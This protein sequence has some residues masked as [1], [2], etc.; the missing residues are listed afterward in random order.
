MPGFII[1]LPF[2]GPHLF[3]DQRH[4]E[5]FVRYLFSQSKGHPAMD[6]TAL[7]L[8]TETE[9]RR[10]TRRYQNTDPKTACNRFISERMPR[11]DAPSLLADDGAYVFFFLPLEGGGGVSNFLRPK[12]DSVA[13]VGDPRI[14]KE[15]MKVIGPNR[16]IRAMHDVLGWRGSPLRGERSDTEELGFKNIDDLTP[17]QHAEVDAKVHDHLMST[18]AGDTLMLVTHHD[19]R[20]AP[21]SWH[22]NPFYH[23]HR[24]RKREA[25][26]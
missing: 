15:G 18:W 2:Q 13:S 23:V 14:I 26:E 10:V 19:Q 16:I 6:R 17:E 7:N 20:T 3:A 12:D 24:L 21:D 1:T 9:A 11:R 8:V 5:N 22:T 25:H 4:A